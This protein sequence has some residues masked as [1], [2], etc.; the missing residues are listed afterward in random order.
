MFFSDWFFLLTPVFPFIYSEHSSNSLIK[1]NQIKQKN[2]FVLG[3]I[4]AQFY[5][6]CNW[7]SAIQGKN[8][9]EEKHNYKTKNY[10][11][12][13]AFLS[14]NFIVFACYTH[15]PSNETKSKSKPKKMAT[16]HVFIV[17]CVNWCV[18]ACVFVDYQEFIKNRPEE[19]VYLLKI[20]FKI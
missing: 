3:N 6:C 12:V 7:L 18:C 15:H 8:F 2:H 17:F 13:I 4:L 16:N 20:C 10:H 19:S 1:P 11:F 9:Y 5:V 14:P